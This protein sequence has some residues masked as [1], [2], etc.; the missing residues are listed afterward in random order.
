MRPF[1]QPLW[2]VVS[3]GGVASLGYL[4]LF[5]LLFAPRLTVPFW[6]FT[7]FSV[8]LTTTLAVL[9]GAALDIAFQHDA[10]VFAAM[11]AIPGVVVGPNNA[12][13]VYR[14]RLSR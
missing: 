5:V 10:P 9:I 1:E 14:V 2:V 4:G 7:S 3:G 11:G 12:L 8:C 6:L 13:G